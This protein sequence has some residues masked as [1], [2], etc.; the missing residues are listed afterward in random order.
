MTKMMKLVAL[1][2]L[3]VAFAGPVVAQSAMKG[4]MLPDHSMRTSKVIGM[5]VYNDS[6]DKI[7]KVF[8][9]L[10]R[11]G[12]EPSALVDVGEFLGARK[13]VQVPLKDIHLEGD[14]PMMM[15]MTRAKLEAMAPFPGDFGSG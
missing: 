8:D 4:V 10:I 15:G 6:G 11:Q 3:A 5:A 2:A 12:S 9:V 14:K 7:G 13:L 1:G